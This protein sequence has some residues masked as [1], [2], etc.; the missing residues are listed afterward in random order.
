MRLDAYL[1]YSRDLQEAYH[2][3]ASQNRWWIYV[4]GTLG[5]ATIAVSGG[6]AAAAASTTAIA[7]V[8][9]SG[10]FSSGFFAFL[11]NDILAG[12]YTAAANSVDDAIASAAVSKADSD[13]CAAA[14][15]ALVKGVSV[16]ATQLE[17]DRTMSAAEALK[18]ANTEKATL[19]KQTDIVVRDLRAAQTES[20]IALPRLPPSI[21]AI[22]P[23][24]INP[25][26]PVPVTL[27][28]SNVNDNITR[29]DLKVKLVSD[30]VAIQVAAPPAATSQ[31]NVYE[32]R[33]MPP[34]DPP[35]PQPP[36]GYSPE[37]VVQGS[38]TIRGNVKLKYSTGLSQSEAARALQT[39]LNAPGLSEEEKVQRLKSIQEAIKA[40]G[41]PPP[42]AIASFITDRRPETE[43]LRVKVAKRLGLIP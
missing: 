21:T 35:S 10:G 3:R 24:S 37:L 32:V 34:K 31:P 11:G 13:Q 12:N 27:T 1:N 19:S 26:S 29:V 22:K 41:A 6:L 18:R 7:I 38:G 42:A 15:V 8:A 5:L 36:D 20:S 16:A 39:F 14:Y 4:A 25:A 43:E 2:S 30:G 33:F 28:V 17:E 40:E 9:I 23:D